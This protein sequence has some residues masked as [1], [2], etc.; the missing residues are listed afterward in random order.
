[1]EGMK[2]QPQCG[3]RARCRCNGAEQAETLRLQ[4][5]CWRGEAQFWMEG[6]FL[7]V[8]YTTS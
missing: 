7:E 8:Y 2:S 5:E 3:E 4:L 1:M 6:A